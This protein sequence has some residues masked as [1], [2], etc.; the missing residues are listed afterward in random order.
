MSDDFVVL[1]ILRLDGFEIGRGQSGGFFG[2][3]A[4]GERAVCGLMDD[5]ARG[6][7]AFGF[8]D[9]PGL[10]SGGDENLAAGG[11][12]AAKRVP[13]GWRGSAATR[14]RPALFSFVQIRLLDAGV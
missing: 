2:E 1:G 7:L 3:R 6:R 9:R 10:R 14:T 5:A 12:D 8:G 11:A 13:I 4:V